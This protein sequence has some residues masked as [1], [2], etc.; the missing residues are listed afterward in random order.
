[1][2]KIGVPVGAKENKFW[3]FSGKVD[4]VGREEI[5]NAVVQLMEKEESKEVRRA[6]KLSDASKKTIEKG[7][8]SYNNLIHLIDELKSLKSLKAL[9]KA[10]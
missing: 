1:V 2:L 6:R 3:A 10:S 4:V 8:D 9:A 5:A 7:G